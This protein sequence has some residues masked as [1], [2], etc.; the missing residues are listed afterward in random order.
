MKCD[1]I[2][3]RERYGDEESAGIINQNTS[4]GAGQTHRSVGYNS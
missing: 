4:V 2:V 3:V 1:E